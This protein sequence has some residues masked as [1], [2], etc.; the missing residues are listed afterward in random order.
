VLAVAQAVQA[1]GRPPANIDVAIA[2]VSAALDLPVGLGPALFA[3]GRTAG[4]V[5][6]V[7]E[8]QASPAV[9]RPRARFV[10]EAA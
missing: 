8:Q 5:A 3:I 1:T 9:L 10:G 6:N 7:L 4:W 2:A